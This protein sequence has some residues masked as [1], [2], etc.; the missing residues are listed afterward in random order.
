LCFANFSIPGGLVALNMFR[1]TGLPYTLISHGHDIPWFFPRQMFW[2]HLM[3]YHTIRNVVLNS[4]LNFVQSDEMKRNIDA[5]TG[6]VFSSKNVVVPNGWN[7]SV[8]APDYSKRSKEFI[9]LFTGR[10]VRQKDP[11]T[12]LKA[13][14]LLNGKIPV[15]LHIMGDGPLR[16]KMET[17]VEKYHL[18]DVCRFFGWVDKDEMLNQYQS[19]SLTVLPSL[20]EGMS[21]ATLEALAC[22][23]YVIAT[24]VSNNEALISEGSNGNLIEIGNYKQLAELIQDF[25]QQKFMKGFLIDEHELDRYRTQY[26]WSDIVKQYDRYFVNLQ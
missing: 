5:F 16:K 2:Y 9:V 24:K 14:R 7:G 12:L 22:G 21:I 20:S 23:Q 18:S 1:R 8:F 25:Y 26:N 19:A 15:R 4:R 17:Y 6:N 10:L 3:L 13:I 11:F